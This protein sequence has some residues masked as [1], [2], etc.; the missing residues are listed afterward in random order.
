MN[1]NKMYTNSLFGRD[2]ET[3]AV[4]AALKSL[5]KKSKGSV[6][7]FT[8]NAGS[9]KSHLCSYIERF[10]SR[11]ACKV[12]SVMA[13]DTEINNSYFVWANILKQLF[14]LKSSGSGEAE[15]KISVSLTEFTEFLL[16]I[17]GIGETF[18]FLMCVTIIRPR[19]C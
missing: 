10:A 18:R 12:V 5:H 11:T 16:Y 7:I 2:A 19:P 9:G 4:H 14:G 1:G 17:H 8:G 6:L 13:L 3:T 15:T